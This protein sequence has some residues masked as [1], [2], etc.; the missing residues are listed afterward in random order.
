M[1]TTTATIATR[2]S[3]RVHLVFSFNVT[4][5][6][7]HGRDFDVTAR[8][9]VISRHGAV[10]VLGRQLATD[11]KVQI[12]YTDNKKKKTEAEVRIVGLIGGQ[13][14]EFVYGVELLDPSVN[15]WG[16]RFPNLMGAEPALARIM[17]QC[18]ACQDREVVHLNEIEIQ[19]FDASQ[20]IQRVCKSCSTMTSW[21]PESNEESGSASVNG[22]EKASQQDSSGQP[23]NGRQKRKHAR[24][25]TKVSACIR[26]VGFPEEIAT[27]EDLSRGGLCFKSRTR[28]IEGSRVEVAVPYSKGSGNIFVPARI[29]HVEEVAGLFRHGAAYV[30]VSEKQEESRRYEPPTPVE[31][32]KK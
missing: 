24:I 27:C 5:T 32:K 21:R 23:P 9:L 14:Q 13:G 16:V 1:T 15:P 7:S 8:T 6:D 20:R 2:R 29:A 28:Y 25:Q 19:V 22:S 17:L 4:G 31:K 11:Q 3:D 26:Q 18:S 10:I 30:T 12:C